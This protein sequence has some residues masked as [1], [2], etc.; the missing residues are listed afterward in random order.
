ME[1]GTEESIRPSC[2]TSNNGFINGTQAVMMLK[3]MEALIGRKSAVSID[4]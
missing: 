4:S 1:N 2:S 3:F